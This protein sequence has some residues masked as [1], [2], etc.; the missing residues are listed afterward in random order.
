MTARLYYKDN[1]IVKTLAKYEPNPW[2]KDGMNARMAMLDMEQT[3]RH[4]SLGKRYREDGKAWKREVK[5]VD[6]RYREAKRK[7]KMA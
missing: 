6:R 4:M 3:V 2:L 5:K 7:L 1:E